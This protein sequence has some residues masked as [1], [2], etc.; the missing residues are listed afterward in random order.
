MSAVASAGVNAVSL[1][2]IVST[3][4]RPSSGRF[5]KIF[6]ETPVV[7]RGPAQVFGLRRSSPSGQ[8]DRVRLSVVLDESG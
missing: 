1:G 6:E 8:R 2:V 3:S 4:R 7:D 5:Q